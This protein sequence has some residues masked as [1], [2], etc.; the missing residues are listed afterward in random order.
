MSATVSDDKGVSVTERGFC[1][2][3]TSNPT[4]S[5]SKIA[6]GSGTGTFSDTIKGLFSNTNYYIRAYA[7]NEAGTSYYGTASYATTDGLPVITSL[8]N[9]SKTHNTLVMSA[10]VSNDN[11]FP[12]TARGFCLGT[13]SNPTIS[14][15]KITVGSGIGT[16]SG[17]ITGLTPN[18]SYYVRAY[19]T[20]EEIISESHGSFHI[21]QLLASETC[22]ACGI[23]D[24]KSG[25]KATQTS[26]ETIKT[27]VL[28]DLG[29][30][31]SAKTREFAVG[32]GVKKEGR[33]PYLHLL[34]WLAD[35][36]NWSLQMDE[37]SNS[38][39]EMKVSLAHVVEKGFLKKLLED[40]STLQDA[41]HFDDHSKILSIED[42]KFFFYLKNIPWNEF[43]KQIGFNDVKLKKPYDFA[44]S[45][46]GENRDLAEEIY[47]QLKSEV[48]NIALSTLFIF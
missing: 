21:A 16:F 24:N 43:A 41:I 2:G 23:I 11:G 1:L 3:T 17:T 13:T 25:K 28:E 39:P 36:S 40:K 14:N 6:V 19:A 48:K 32:S 26:I 44:L 15:S 12:V 22:I 10:T 8:S 30:V 18:T 38:Y 46:A 33:A 34:K 42:P 45:F 31:F 20:K 7:T 27:K 5:N 35:S 29:R 9:T 47:N 37:V 4:I